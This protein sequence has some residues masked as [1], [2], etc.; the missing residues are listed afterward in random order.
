MPLVAFDFDGTLTAA[1][2]NVLLGQL[3]GAE[4][5]MATITDRA[6]NGDLPYSESLRSRVALLEGLPVAEVDRALSTV[7][8]RPGATDVLAA[9]SDADVPVVILTG[10]FERGVRSALE[11]AGVA[12]DRV[13]ANRLVA[14]DGVLTG[15]VTGPLVDGAKVAIL[16]SLA[17]EHGVP[18]AAVVAVG[19]GANDRSLLEAAGFA[20]GY[21]PKPAVRDVLDDSVT[22]MDDLAAALR[23]HGVLPAERAN[24]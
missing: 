18:L 10:G 7:E 6:M 12:V 3:I 16:E 17:T 20:I 15:E 4:T 13:V 9:L 5:E 19:D 21:E 2:M 1:E 22:S 24:P 8:L 11:A 23:R 14:A